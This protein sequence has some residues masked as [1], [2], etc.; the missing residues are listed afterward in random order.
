MSLDKGKLFA[1]QCPVGVK[2]KKHV[3]RGVLG[4]VERK[5]TS[6][7]GADSP[8]PAWNLAAVRTLPSVRPSLFAFIGYRRIAISMVSFRES[9][10][11]AQTNTAAEYSEAQAFSQ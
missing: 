9:P 11:T 4:G 6:A 2:R 7:H 8:L 1:S 10:P 5:H 3:R